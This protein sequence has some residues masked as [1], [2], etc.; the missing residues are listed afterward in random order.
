MSEHMKVFVVCENKCF[1]EGMTKEQVY[2][3]IEESMRGVVTKVYVENVIATPTTGG[4]ERILEISNSH[5]TR[6]SFVEIY[7]QDNDSM[8]WMG[9]C[10]DTTK[11]TFVVGEGYI[12]LPLVAQAEMTTKPKLV[13]RI[14]DYTNQT[15]GKVVINLNVMVSV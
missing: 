6:S 4:G 2:E 5:I 15:N 1:V 3:A 7:P 12:V 9:A 10:V 14:T 11:W 8:A 13:L